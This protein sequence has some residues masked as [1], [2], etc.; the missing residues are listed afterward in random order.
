MN[1]ICHCFYKPILLVFVFFILSIKISFSTDTFLKDIIVTT[2][3]KD[4]WLYFVTEGCFKKEMERAILSSVPVTFTFKATLGQKRRFWLDKKIHS[5][6]IYHT[7]KY[8]QLKDVF[9]IKRSEAPEQIATSKDFIWAKK[10]MATVEAPLVP[11][12]SLKKGERYQL[13]LKAE[14]NKVKLPFYLHYIFFFT[15]LWDFETDWQYINFVY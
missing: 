15:S 6:K 4:L 1:Y 12:S 14:L 8:D 5:V 7:I 10:I 9:V 2:S 11:L 13:A 3:K